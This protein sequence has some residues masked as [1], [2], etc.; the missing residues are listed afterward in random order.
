MSYVPPGCSQ[1]EMV[2]TDDDLDGPDRLNHL[3]LNFH[4][5]LG[6]IDPSQSHPAVCL[7]MR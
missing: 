5:M 1:R 7:S 2:V 6:V 3:D 4:V